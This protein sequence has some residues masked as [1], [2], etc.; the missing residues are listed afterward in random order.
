MT[1]LPMYTR[2]SDIRT[3][4]M[5]AGCEASWLLSNLLN[6]ELP[7]TVWFA[8][9][10]SIHEA[11]EACILHNL[12]KDE[13]I[14]YGHGA[15]DVE[16]G[17]EI[18]ESASKR[19]KRNL[20][21]VRGDMERMLGKWWDDVHPMS[22]TRNPIFGKYVWPPKVEHNIVNKPRD[23]AL[24]LFTQVDAI[25]THNEEKFGE[26]IL[27]VDWK[28]GAKATSDPAQLHTYMYGGRKEGWIKDH[29]QSVVGMFWHIDHSKAQWVDDYLGD[30]VVEAWIR[31]TF[32]LKKQVVSN[33]MPVYTPDWYCGYCR[34]RGKCP[35]KGGDLSHED[36]GILIM[37]ATL[38]HEPEEQ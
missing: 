32:E 2:S 8:L 33:L 11:I 29:Q 14:A 6:D 9:G 23:K 35:V 36:V 20:S 22:P 7:G 17:G 4:A 37:E 10:T 3:L 13:M 30:E 19:S 34:A 25:F 21:T 24:R 12:T 38:V 1:T 18:I 26:E 31:R 28:S 15:L 16:L 5:N 27:I